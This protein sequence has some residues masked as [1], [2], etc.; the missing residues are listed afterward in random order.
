MKKTSIFFLIISVILIITGVVLKNSALKDAEKENIELFRQTL[1]EN[2]DLIET[3]EFSIEDTNKINID[4][5]NANV[6]IIGNA[7]KS[8][9]EIINFNALEYVSYS[10]NRAFTIQDHRQQAR[11]IFR[12]RYRVG[13]GWQ[14]YQFDQ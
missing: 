2:G 13:T 8:Y 6:N 12:Y 14:N 10:N 5:K 9:A 11:S 3:V 7:E 1:T 4:I